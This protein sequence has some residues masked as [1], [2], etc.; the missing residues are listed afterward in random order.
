M[1]RTVGFKPD[2][3][4]LAGLV[5]RFAL[6]TLRDEVTKRQ[7]IGV[8]LTRRKYG[9]GIVGVAAAARSILGKSVDRLTS[10]ERLYLAN[11][12]LK[13]GVAEQK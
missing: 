11:E 5:N 1:L 4:V 6:L 10:G 8:I 3:G 13:S 12:T 7:A 2:G 9:S